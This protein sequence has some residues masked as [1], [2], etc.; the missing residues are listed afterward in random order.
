MKDLHAGGKT[1]AIL[2]G[3]ALSLVIASEGPA[4]AQRSG[5]R[6]APV[7]RRLEQLSRQAD[8]YE[9]DKL[10]RDLKGPPDKP[11]E[12]SLDPAL[13][14]Q[15]KQ[16]FEGLQAGY[17]RIVIA[18]AAKEGLNLDS[19]LSAL[20]EVKKCSTRLKGNL[21]LP[22]PNG[23][24]DKEEHREVDPAQIGGSLLTLRKHIYNFVTNPL[25]EA[26]AAL[27][28]EKATEAS[29]DLDRIV[30]LSESIRKSAGL[31]KAH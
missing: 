29:R 1:Q 18:M 31:K 8:E 16:D 27:D 7:D 11:S 21:A 3:A 24:K 14:T 19:V 28:I 10:S 15:I 26:R 4:F 22:R 23:A 5:S 6:P 13:A 30:E 12:R 2:I 20:I 25:F 17:N 9:R